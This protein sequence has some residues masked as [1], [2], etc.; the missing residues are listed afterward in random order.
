MFVGRYVRILWLARAACNPSTGG[1]SGGHAN[2]GADSGHLQCGARVMIRTRGPIDGM[3]SII[4][5][6]ASPRM[7]ATER[8]P[9][10]RSIRLHVSVETSLLMPTGWQPRYRVGLF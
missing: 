9:S 6:R 4:I 5:G 8:W 10:T 1:V 7:Y 2:I 3:A